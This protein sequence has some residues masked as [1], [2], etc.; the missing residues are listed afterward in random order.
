M[1]TSPL[2]SSSEGDPQQRTLSIDP[3]QHVTAIHIR[4]GALIDGMTM[5]RSD[6]HRVTVG[7]TG[8]SLI[9]LTWRP[10]DQNVL[11][12]FYGGCGGHLHNVGVVVKHFVGD[13]DPLNTRDTETTAPTLS[14]DVLQVLFDAHGLT[15]DVKYV[16]PVFSYV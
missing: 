16:N 3:Q 12:G 8:G 6:G 4:A 11:L 13:A 14:A 7:G 10:D 15:T 9:E 5:V 1:L 2:F